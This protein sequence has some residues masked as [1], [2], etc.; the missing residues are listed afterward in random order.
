MALQSQCIHAMRAETCKEARR[1][2]EKN[3][4]TLVLTDA[5]MPDGTWV[6]VVKS[7]EKAGT[8]VTVLIV[9]ARIDMILSV[10]PFQ[11]SGDLTRR[12]LGKRKLDF[13]VFT[14][15]TRIGAAETISTA[16]VPELSKSTL[17]VNSGM[18]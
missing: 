2:I 8:T 3:R 16:T 6:D 7:A 17:G 14:G 13:V 15:L 5:L 4:P 1:L 18:V 11:H 9:A 12:R 10:K